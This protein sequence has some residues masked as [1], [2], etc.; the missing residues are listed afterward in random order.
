MEIRE[1]EPDFMLVP[2]TIP[3]LQIL[4]TIRA[5]T[6][7][8]RKD[9]VLNVNNPVETQNFLE[10]NA[11][12]LTPRYTQGDYDELKEF[13]NK[14]SKYTREYSA[15]FE[16]MRK[17]FP[18]NDVQYGDLSRLFLMLDEMIKATGKE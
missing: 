6:C 10:K 13:R 1:R 7:R 3:E 12:V 9:F 18:Q 11:I 17:L 14:E 5:S 2:E 16:K 8:Y 15:L 4:E